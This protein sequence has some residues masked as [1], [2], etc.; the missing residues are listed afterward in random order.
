MHWAYTRFLPSAIHNVNYFFPGFENRKK[1]KH[2]ANEKSVHKM[3]MYMYEVWISK[4]TIP[5]ASFN[6]NIYMH[7]DAVMLP[8]FAP[9]YKRK[10]EIDLWQAFLLHWLKYQIGIFLISTNAHIRTFMHGNNKITTTKQRE[11][12][13]QQRKEKS[14][15]KMAIAE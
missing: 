15:N 14:G 12:N 9:L 7:I 6:H 2:R 3:Y 1:G 13:Q 4:L 10:W 11:Q 8:F 5:L